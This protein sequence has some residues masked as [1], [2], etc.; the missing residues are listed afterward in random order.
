MKNVASQT[1]GVDP[2]EGRRLGL[3]V[4][5][6][7][8]DTRLEAGQRDAPAVVGHDPSVAPATRRASAGRDG[9]DLAREHLRVGH[10]VEV[11]D[12]DHRVAG[13]GRRVGCRGDFPSGLEWSTSFVEAYRAR[14]QAEPPIDIWAV[15]AY[16][17]DWE[18][19]PQ[20]NAER[21]RVGG[22]SKKES[23]WLCDSKSE[24]TW[25]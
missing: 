6:D 17:L 24:I 8:G 2:N 18:T 19:L 3:N 23:A 4:A 1:L 22:F 20:G 7:K 12:L 11:A 21:A 5:H 16:D 10:A 15:H 14:F 25:A 13:V 9:E